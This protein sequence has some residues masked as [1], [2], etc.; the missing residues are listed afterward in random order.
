LVGIA[1]LPSVFA[2]TLW[3]NPLP[4]T[5]LNSAAGSSRSNVAPVYGSLC[6]PG[7][8]N[9]DS[10]NGAITGTTNPYIL[11]DQFVL[12]GTTNTIT[13]VTVY[14]V[15]NTPTSGTIDNP[16]DEFSDI[17]LFI[18]AD[19]AALTS[20]S[21]SYSFQQ[22][23]YNGTTDYESVNTAGDFFPIFAITFSGL[24]VN[25]GP[26]TYDFA[27][28]ATPIGG[29][30]FALLMSDPSLS[31]PSEDSAS[32]SPNNGFLY[33]FDDGNGP[34]A[35]YQYGP[36]SISNY[37]NGADAN[38]IISGTAT[39]EPST[40]AMLGMGLLAAWAGLRRRSSVR[41]L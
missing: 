3:T 16:T 32:L 13:D 15:G 36:G 8:G 2:D 21:S 33:Y 34:I 20:I 24:N 19:Q 4:T 18:G 7:T 29:N 5:N 1:I 26:G 11:G 14:E 28:G 6:D 31:G 25:L 41:P 22:V 27:I 40:L 38:V 10:G 12:S 37:N 35:G 23:Q 30:T 39:P 17:T 9:C